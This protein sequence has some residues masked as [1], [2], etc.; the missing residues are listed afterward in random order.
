MA[1]MGTTIVNVLR[2][3]NRGQEWKHT[4]EGELGALVEETQTRGASTATN[5]VIQSTGQQTV[6]DL[7]GVAGVGGLVAAGQLGLVTA[8]GGGLLDGQVVGHRETDLGVALV[9]D[10]VAIV[11]VVGDLLRLG[12]GGRSGGEESDTRGDAELHCDVV[13]SFGPFFLDIYV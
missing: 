6:V 12:K 3:V 11:D 10:A 9:V 8:L 5:Q 2:Y 13:G 4:L 7:G 1:M